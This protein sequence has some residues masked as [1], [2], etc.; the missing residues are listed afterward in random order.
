MKSKA[1]APFISAFPIIVAVL[2][3]ISA[4]VSAATSQHPYIWRNVKVGAGGFI[5][6][7]VFSRVEKGLVYLR[8]DMGGCYRWDDSPKI[9]IPLQDSMAESSYFGGES[10]APDPI[11][12]TPSISP[13]ECT[14][15]IR[16]PCCARAIAARPG[17]SSPLLSAWVATKTAAASVNAWPSIQT[18]TPFS[19]S[20][21]AMTA[22]GAVPIPRKP[23]R[24]SPPFLSAAAETRPTDSR[25][26]P[27]LSFVVFDPRTG[28]RGSPTRTIFVGSADPGP[29]HLFRSDDAGITWS[30]VP[31]R[32]GAGNAPRPGPN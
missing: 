1:T 25:R 17:M 5:P 9:W 2:L 13:P 32:P 30:A 18:T 27:G 31:G 6:G 4:W 14:A 3:A 7:I 10:I 28:S 23:G 12:P 24:K 29:Q 26:T 11:D 19:F 20:P 22:F 21:R 15:P 8:S 16:R